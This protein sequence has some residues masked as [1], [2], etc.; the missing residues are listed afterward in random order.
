MLSSPTR[1]RWIAFVMVAIGV[2]ACV[3]S[4][5]FRPYEGGGGVVSSDASPEIPAD[6]PALEDDAAPAEPP[7]DATAPTPTFACGANGKCKCDPAGQ[8]CEGRCDQM[9]SCGAFSCGARSCTFSCTDGATCASFACRDATECSVECTKHSTCEIDCTDND[10][11]KSVRCKDGSACLL[12]CGNA[13]KCGFQE[14]SGGTVAVMC[15][16]GIIACN[17]PCP[18]PV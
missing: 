5:D 14:C 18:L 9:A 1:M 6:V 15:P 13:T 12:H 11:C 16:G 3:A 4:P 8:K 2:A 10:A 7:G 17:R